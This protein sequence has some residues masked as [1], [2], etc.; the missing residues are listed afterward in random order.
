MSL[1][2]GIRI[3]GLKKLVT[4]LRKKEKYAIH[5]RNLKLYQKL[6]LKVTKF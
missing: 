3:D 4:M 5:C 6:G 1:K 2:F